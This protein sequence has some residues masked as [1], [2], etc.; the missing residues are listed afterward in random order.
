[1]S[2][3]LLFPAVNFYQLCLTIKFF[4]FTLYQY[5]NT[6]V[7]TSLLLLHS[8]YL[9]LSVFQYLCLHKFIFV[10]L[11]WIVFLF[12]HT[13]VYLFLHASVC[14]F[15]EPKASVRWDTQ[16]VDK[17]VI[18]S[19]HFKP[20]MELSFSLYLFSSTE[21]ICGWEFFWK[22][23]PSCCCFKFQQMVVI[24]TIIDAVNQ[25]NWSLSIKLRFECFVIVE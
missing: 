14:S 1:M 23:Q 9:P 13:V 7:Y 21:H 2:F 20:L 16:K 10:L 25:G 4:L 3:L 8:F 17:N 11:Q 19:I 15:H 12:L 22:K 5:F 24:L 18:F 6:Y